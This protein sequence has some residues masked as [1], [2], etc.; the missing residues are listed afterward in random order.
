MTEGEG[1][2]GYTRN[3]ERVTYAGVMRA[4]GCRPYNGLSG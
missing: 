2:L 4:A 1:G 3:D